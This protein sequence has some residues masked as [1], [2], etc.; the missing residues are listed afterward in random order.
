MHNPNASRANIMGGL[1]AGMQKTI[2]PLACGRT[3]SNHHPQQQQLLQQCPH[4]SYYPP[5]GT[6]WQQP[7]PLAQFGGMPP[8]SGSYCQ[9]TTM[10]MP[11][12]QLGQ[13]MMM[14]A[15]STRQASEMCC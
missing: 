9:Q 8:A 7:T 3:P 2:L 10:A 12:Y 1:V 11:V 13:G 15:G 14:N 5:G 4:I 6:A